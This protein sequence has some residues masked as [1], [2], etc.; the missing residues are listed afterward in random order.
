MLYA[1]SVSGHSSGMRAQVKITPA[2]RQGV[3]VAGEGIGMTDELHDRLASAL[4]NLAIRHEWQPGA[5]PCLCDQHR[6]AKAALA[7]YR[8]A[9]EKQDA[10]PKT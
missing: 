10:Q 5:G 1:I 3:A 7:A 2:A 6:I 4:T 9:K 8:D